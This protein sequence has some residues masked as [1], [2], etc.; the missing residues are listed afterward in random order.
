MEQQHLTEAACLLNQGALYRKRIGL[1]PVG[2]IGDPIF[3]GFKQGAFSLYFGDA[4]IYHFD[5]EG[6]WQ[7]AFLE[8]VHYLKGLDG[9]IHAVDRVREG[10]NLVLHRR[11]LGYEEASQV[12]GGIRDVALKLQADLGSG[13]LRFLEPPT[14]KAQPLDRDELDDFLERIGR[15]DGA[16]WFAHRERYLGTYGPL[17]FLPP[18]CL[19]AIVLQATLG[20]A[21]GHSFGLGRSAEYYVRSGTEFEQHAREV[22]ALWGRRLAQTR[23]AFLA[24]SDVLR[25]PVGDVAAYLDAVK[26]AFPL[27]PAD[28]TEADSSAPRIEGIHAFL[29]DFTPPL[30]DRSAWS[31]F[32][33]GG[34]VRLSLGVESGDPT[35]RAVY[36]KHWADEEF[37]TCVADIKAAGLAVSLMTLVGAGGVDRAESHVRETSALIQTLDLRAGDH[38]FLIDE[39]EVRD[40]H[41]N[42]PGVT[43]LEGIARAEQQKQFKEQLNPLRKRGVKVLAYTLEKQWT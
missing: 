41:S 4:P 11:R 16:T 22:A 10:P 19:N 8:G 42:E 5:L 29:D 28:A 6:R 21:G 7:R 26:M 24:G 32:A 14:G 37:R 43:F 18:D 9:E 38:V 13:A 12:D 20:H 39:D 31:Q 23:V 1:E 33:A 3:A 34:L 2:A 27:Q 35:I 36:G 17:P 25:R 40:T 15:W 30:P